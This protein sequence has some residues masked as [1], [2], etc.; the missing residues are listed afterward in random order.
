MV[1]IYKYQEKYC[2]L[3][4]SLIFR[5]LLVTHRESGEVHTFPGHQES[6]HL[7]KSWRN[8]LQTQVSMLCVFHH[9]MS[10][11]LAEK[12]T[13]MNK[14]HMLS[15]SFGR[16]FS[17]PSK[18]FGRWYCF[19]KGEFS[20][21]SG[22]LGTLDN[23]HRFTEP[24]CFLWLGFYSKVE[25]ATPHQRNLSAKSTNSSA[26]VN[27]LTS[28]IQKP[29]SV[30]DGHMVFTTFIIQSIVVQETV[31]RSPVRHMWAMRLLLARTISPPQSHARR[32]WSWDVVWKS[33]EKV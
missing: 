11:T 21:F 15:T 27:Y 16:W 30:R 14:Q 22:W 7:M 2:N 20:S 12:N 25:G 5:L 9:L 29:S 18:R 23:G 28:T 33:R 6:E 24:I 32:D 31:R 3:F 1:Q 8:S 4:P 17:T 26:I 10:M 19:F 13:I